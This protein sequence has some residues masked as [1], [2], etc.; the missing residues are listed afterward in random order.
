VLEADVGV[1]D[2]SPVIPSAVELV[3]ADEGKEP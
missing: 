2:G 3:A 1:E